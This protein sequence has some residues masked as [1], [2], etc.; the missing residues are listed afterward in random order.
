MKSLVKWSFGLVGILV[1]GAVILVVLATHG[2]LFRH[3]LKQYGVRVLRERFNADVQLST[4]NIL[5]YP[6]VRIEGTGLVLRQHD[7]ADIP[8]LITVKKFSLSGRF[9]QVIRKARHF[10]TLHLEGLHIQVPPRGNPKRPSEQADEKPQRDDL[11]FTID[12]VKAQDAELDILRNSDKP[13]L[14]F[15]LHDLNLGSVQPDTPVLFHA[16]LTN[17]KPVGEI[18]SHGEFGPWDKEEP[19]LTPVSGEYSFS[20]ADLSTIRGISG[21]LSSQGSFGGVLNYIHVQGETRTP[22]FALAGTGHAVPLTTTYDAIVDG[23]NGNTIL[24]SVRA[25]FLS[26]VINTSGQVAKRPGDT[27]RSILLDAWSRDARVENLLRLAVRSPQPVLTGSVGLRAKIVIPPRKDLDMIDRLNVKGQFGIDEAQFTSTTVQEKIDALSRRGR[28]EPKA[29]DDES[30]LSSLAGNFSLK[31][32]AV[33]FSKLTF[34]VPGAVVALNGSYNLKSEEVDFRGALRLQAKLS[35]T[36]TG[37]KS[38]FLKVAD[39]LFKRKDAGAVLAIKVTGT[40]EKPS[41]GVDMRS[42]LTRKVN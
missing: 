22:D 25:R 36:T 18:D 33:R 29:M 21:T 28:G 26:S 13:A 32:G 15:L 24:K 38:F 19:S 2:G 31:D 5:L 10:R 42:T 7:R 1:F 39:P 30:A 35:Q 6:S 34:E 20:N 40:R 23:T 14:V 3:E 41:F 9:P 16:T 37:V 17:P 12:E 4:L 11:R 27:G 8:P